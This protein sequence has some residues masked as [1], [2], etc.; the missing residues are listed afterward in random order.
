L[1]ARGAKVVKALNTLEGIDLDQLDGSPAGPL[2]AFVAGDDRSAIDTACKLVVD[3]G[4]RPVELGELDFAT[5]ECIQPGGELFG[6]ALTEHHALE[7]LA[8]LRSSQ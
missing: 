5:V 3:A 2:A 8:K 6:L 7:L 1:R 4:F